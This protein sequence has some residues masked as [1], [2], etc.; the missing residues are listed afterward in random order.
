MMATADQIT[1]GCIR[2]T[3]E[4][5]NAIPN[6]CVQVL[7][8]KKSAPAT[9]APGGAPPMD[10][11]RFVISDGVHFTGALL[12]TGLNPLVV[13]DQI[14]KNGIICLK[15]AISNMIQGKRILV[16]VDCEPLTPGVGLEHR[17]GNPVGWDVVGESTEGAQAQKPIQPQQGNQFQQQQYLQQQQQQQ[18]R[19][20][21]QKL[22]DTLPN[23]FQQQQQPPQ[24]QYAPQRSPF[25]SQFK[26]E[27][28]APVT[29]NFNTMATT[30]HNAIF[31]ILSL[32]PYQS[33]WMIRARV[34]NRSDIKNWD[35]G[36]TSGKLF[37]CTLVDE[38]G[39]IKLTGFN[40]AVDTFYN[41]LQ[42]GQIVYVSKC[43]V[44]PARKQYSTTKAEYELTMDQ[45]TQ[46]TPCNEQIS[47]PSAIYTPVEIAKLIEVEKDST[48]DC[49]TILKEVNDITQLISKTTNKPNSKRDI[50]LVDNSGY[51]VR[52]TLWGATAEKFDSPIGSVV[53]IKG[54]K[55]SDW[56]GRTLSL[57]FSSTIEINPDLQ[58]AHELRG[59]YEEI[60]HGTSFQQFER[61]AGGNGGAGGGNALGYKT[62]HQIKEEELGFGD[63]TDLFV[64]RATV[65][66]VKSENPF[67]PACPK[68]GCN[69]KVIES[70]GQ[71]RC[72]KCDMSYPSPKYRYIFTMTVT[73]HTGNIWVNMFN[74]PAEKMLK[75]TADE[76]AQLRENNK[77]H[78]DHYFQQCLFQM[79][80]LKVRAKSEMYQDEAKVKYIVSEC[81]PVDFDKSSS[82]LLE[83]IEAYHSA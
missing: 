72:E 21:P 12:T 1:T 61:G 5:G 56:G 69:K 29:R 60:G 10:R 19:Q 76:L 41:M 62:I 23:Q 16:I 24:N 83:T 75:A 81:N 78:Y 45:N 58:K 4:T 20:P 31:P 57:G 22:Q 25:E 39:D 43:A 51:M 46:I 59:W 13:Q 17:I 66:F 38:S 32:S 2:T 65:T 67:Y 28:S 18:Q 3:F 49:I 35:N 79:V 53:A 52:C 47:L 26:K 80:T 15:K 30:G 9:A 6:M 7:T 77:D 37:N 33:K 82:L 74:E 68:E 11:Y 63:R 42:D 48:I 50:T 64:L 8:I 14:V 70:N 44:K 27:Q 54:A 40:D 34:T 36:R 55:V 73:D 71:W